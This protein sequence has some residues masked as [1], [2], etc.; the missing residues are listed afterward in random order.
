MGRTKASSSSRATS[1]SSS[2][3]CWTTSPRAPCTARYGPYPLPLC[4]DP[5]VHAPHHRVCQG[6]P[7][8]ESAP[9]PSLA[10]PAGGRPRRVQWVSFSRRHG[11]HPTCGGG[12]RWVSG[13][14]RCGGCAARGRARAAGGGYQPLGSGGGCWD[15][16]VLTVTGSS[17]VMLELPL[18][19]KPL[20]RPPPNAPQMFSSVIKGEL[21]A[22]QTFV[23]DHNPTPTQLNPAHLQVR[24]RC[25]ATQFEQFR[26]LA[27]WL[28]LESSNPL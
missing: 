10:S 14:R 16:N 26:Q 22:L 23:A 24:S 15:C 13:Y 18:E 9:P 8:I 17:G 25:C 2:S 4:L 7:E 6:E 27:L 3:L 19:F 5:P 28:P 12:V 21:L 1:T 20:I 11:P